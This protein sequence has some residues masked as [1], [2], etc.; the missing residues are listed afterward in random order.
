VRDGD[1]IVDPEP[2]GLVRLSVHY[3]NGGMFVPHDAKAHGSLPSIK[4]RTGSVLAGP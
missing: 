2:V 1:I 3:E 4:K